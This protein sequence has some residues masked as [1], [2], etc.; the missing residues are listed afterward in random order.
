MTGSTLREG[1]QRVDLRLSLNGQKRAFGNECPKRA[2][3]TTRP[4]SDGPLHIGAR[5]SS[6]PRKSQS[7]RRLPLTPPDYLV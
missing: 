3:E 7:H 5:L 4:L 1:T 6:H 2:F